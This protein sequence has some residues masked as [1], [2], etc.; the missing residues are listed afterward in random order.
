MLTTRRCLWLRF[1][2]WFG[3]GQLHIL[4]NQIALHVACCMC[5]WIHVLRK[6]DDKHMS[7]VAVLHFVRNENYAQKYD[8][9]YAYCSLDKRVAY[10][11]GG[12]Y[13]SR[14]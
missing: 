6:S 11:R 1:R 14:I 8:G 5:P 12:G 7:D 10:T 9:P 4:G 3:R 13:I 2:G